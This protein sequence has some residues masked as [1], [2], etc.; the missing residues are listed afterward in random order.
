M[1]ARDFCDSEKG[2]NKVFK[3]SLQ[4]ELE[5]GQE[6]QSRVLESFKFCKAMIHVVDTVLWPISETAAEALPDLSFSHYPET[7]LRCLILSLRVSWI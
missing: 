5:D 1:L 2:T 3:V 4:L 7:H 6:G